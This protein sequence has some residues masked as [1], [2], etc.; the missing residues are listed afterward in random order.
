MHLILTMDTGHSWD[1]EKKTSGIKDM[2]PNMVANGILKLHKCW[3]ILRIQDIGYSRVEFSRRKIIETQ[4]TSMGSVAIFDLVYRT[5]G[6]VVKWCGTNSGE[7]SQSRL[8]SA[9]KMSPENQIKP[10]DL[11]LFRETER[12]EI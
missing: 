6:A 9:R 12:S 8:E 10:E 3:K 2:Q 11:K 4:S 7:V 1:L 5:Y